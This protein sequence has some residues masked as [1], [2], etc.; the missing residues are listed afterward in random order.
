MKQESVILFLVFLSLSAYS[1]GSFLFNNVDV[2]PVPLVTINTAPGSFNPANG[3]AGAFIGSDYTASLYYLNG[4]VTDQATFDSNN[5]IFFPS[6]D[7]LFLGTTGF[8]TSNGAGQFAGGI[9]NLPTTGTVSV[10]VRAWYN[11]GGVYSSYDQALAGGQN[12]GKSNPVVLT[13]AVGAPPPPQMNGLLP[14]TVA[15]VPEPSTFALVGLGGLAL[16]LFR[17][18]K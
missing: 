9:M 6:A 12:V 17:R 1:Q 15:V 2:E 7:T 11:G 3:P 16:L 18:R 14:F 13:L 10:Q 5:P 8:T 4:A